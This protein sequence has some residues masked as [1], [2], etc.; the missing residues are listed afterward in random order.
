MKYIFSVLL[1]LACGL[2]HAQTTLSTRNK[3][4]IALY[5]EA[6]NFRV[7]GQ[8][9]EAL[10][11]LKQAV[12]KDKDFVEAYFRQA[13]IYKAIRDYEQSNSTFLH[14]LSMTSDPRM[15]KGF[16]YELGDNYLVSGDYEKALSFLNRY[17]DSEMMNKAKVN[18][19]TLWKR[20]A[21]YALR[22]QKV[23][24]Q[25][26]PRELSDTVNAFAMQYFP[27]LTADEQELI[28]T[29]RLGGGHEDDEDLVVCT[30]D[31][32]GRWTRPV[33][34]SSKINSRLNEG[35]C[36]I[37]ADGRQLIFTS[38]IGRRGYGSCDLFESRKIGGEWTVPVNLGP[39]VNSPAWESQP[40][41]SADGRTLF[42]V[43]ERRGGVGG[44]DIYVSY[45]MEN[46]KWTKAENL[47]G[48]INTP[49]DEI[50]P[51]IHVNG[52]TLFLASNGK[53]GFGGYDLYRSER[54]NG[55]WSAT[56]NFGYPVNNHEDQFSLFITAD[57]QRGFY[58]HEENQKAN[59]SKII[60]INVPKEL[61][62]QYKSNYV[63]GIVR[64]RQTKAPLGATVELF[65]INRN[66]L[67]SSVQADSITGEYLMV[68][69]QGADYALYVTQPGYLFQNLNFNY[70]IQKNL[71]PVAMD[72][73]LDPVKV[74]AS[75]VLKNIFFDLNKYELKERSMTELA[76]VI[77][78]MND[79]PSVQVEISGHTDDLGTASYN[80]QL[81][82]Q[83]AK[84]VA[85]YLSEHGIDVSRLKQ[86][87][88]GAEKALMPNDSD[89]NRQT[90]R[91]IEFRL[92]R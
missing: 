10:D 31:A 90:N 61:Q 21:E 6:D 7:R 79:N 59:S 41:L 78:F 26:Q 20:N 23:V 86:K 3:K 1:A 2:S 44:K 82:Q 32:A 42:F 22:N 67:M 92:L 55:K 77:R 74:G 33:S 54:E 15:Q 62:F 16:F 5:N 24:A 8:Y 18:Q 73:F 71:I 87:G 14:A 29:R 57:G 58:S 88:Y 19:A 80:L 50:S 69:T 46:G 17:L 76:R 51:F 84:A 47:G 70:E 53:I 48:K 40:S 43:S 28:F 85:D 13:L 38:C 75:A 60:E 72:I 12:E 66:E 65:N 37:S 11:L 91:R 64:D 63:K 36:T 30:K 39:E 4:A 45:K 68:L 81:S 35:T 25:F 9:R 83:R 34:I 52:R 56:E 89:E 49:Y 27:V